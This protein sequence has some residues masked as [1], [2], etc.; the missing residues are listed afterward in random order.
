MRRVGRLQVFGSIR[1]AVV[2]RALL[3]LALDVKAYKERMRLTQ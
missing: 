1:E 3:V 2:P